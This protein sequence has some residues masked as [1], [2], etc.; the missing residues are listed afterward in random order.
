MITKRHLLSVAIVL[1]GLFCLPTSSE[2]ATH[3]LASCM[4]ADIQANISDPSTVDGDVIVLP[5]GS[6]T[7]NSNVTI[8]DTKGIT[9]QGAGSNQ[10]IVTLGGNRLLLQTS[11]LRSPV[12]ITGVTF[13]KTNTTSAIRIVG[14]A[15]NWRIDHNVF[16]GGGFT[17]GHIIELGDGTPNTDAFTYGV[18]DHN[19]FTAYGIR[20]IFIQWNRTYGGLDGTTPGNWIWSQ[21]PER[22]T[23]QAVYIENNVFNNANGQNGQL[24][25][26]RWGAKYVLRYN[27]IFNA[28]ISTHSG[29]TNHG[30]NPLWVEIYGNTESSNGNRPFRAIELR[31]VSGVVWNNTIGPD[32]PVA[33]GLDFERAWRSDCGTQTIFNQKADGT[34]AFDENVDIGWRALGQP[35]WGQPQA[36]NMSAYTFAGVFAWQNTQGASTANLVLQNTSAGPLPNH[37]NAYIVAGRELFNSANMTIGLIGNRPPT[38]S[39][40]PLNRSV[41]VSTDE[42]AQGA[43]LYVCTPSNTW[44]KHWEPFTYPHPLTLSGGMPPPPPPYSQSSYYSESAYYAQSAYYAESSYTPGINAKFKIG[45]RV[46]TTQN[47]NVRNQP[48]LSK[49]RIQGTQAT[50]SLGAILDGPVIAD[51][52]TWWRVDYDNKPDGWSADN[53]L[54]KSLTGQVNG[55]ATASIEEQI[56]QLQLQLAS[57]Q[58]Q[59]EALLGR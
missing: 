53:W 5:P 9:L 1:G 8:P 38:C 49:G 32:H 18:I 37:S 16:D 24:V 19:E 27:T 3:N 48:S 13:I 12:R 52:Y 7:W 29:C 59:L 36:S 4:S 6:C 14:T 23:A 50:G 58:R 21:P 56:H 17:S 22:G 10:T 30:R 45:D 46:I 2:A 57:L 34:R 25:D 31:S 43:T 40:G 26:A 47:L 35:G 39:A 42:N 44:T 51:G 55:A 28:W 15:R 54:E 41:Y 11:S 20:G 33:I